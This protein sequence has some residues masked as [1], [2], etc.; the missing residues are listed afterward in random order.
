M[1]KNG[2]TDI[3]VQAC[4]FELQ[5]YI[6]GVVSLKRN[7]RALFMRVLPGDVSNLHLASFG[8]PVDQTR[9]ISEK[10]CL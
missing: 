5:Y 1:S 6:R 3:T 7:N 8:K 9:I 10:R 4:F 2:A